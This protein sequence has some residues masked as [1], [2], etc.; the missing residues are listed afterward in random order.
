MSKRKTGRRSHRSAEEARPGM[1]A[2]ELLSLA[3]EDDEFQRRQAEREG[4]AEA[5]FELA[6]ARAKEEQGHLLTR[7]QEQGYDIQLLEELDERYDAA[8]YEDIVGLLV[9]GLASAQTENLVASLAGALDH[10]CARGKAA[11]VLIDAFAKWS[12]TFE[13]G[14]SLTRDL[15]SGAIDTTATEAD[16]E[17]VRALVEEPKYRSHIA[18]LLPS[19]GRLLKN[20]AVEFLLTLLP[21]R[22]SAAMAIRTLGNLRAVSA[23]ADIEAFLEDED[24]YFRNEAKKALSKFETARRTGNY[25]P[26][27]PRLRG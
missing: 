25:R 7:I 16:A 10:R 11:G 27:V 9:D 13:I 24:P 14:T 15:L 20:Q 1:T 23:E 4:R 19:Y 3:A 18:L 22:A 5:E 17:R 6:V 12:H 21:D 8:G 2:A 26:R